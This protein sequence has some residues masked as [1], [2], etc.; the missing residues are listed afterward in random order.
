MKDIKP[1]LERKDDFM[2]RIIIPIREGKPM[3]N[4]ADEIGISR[5]RLYGVLKLFGFRNRKDVLEHDTYK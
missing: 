1:W 5:Q 4:I 2:S 3:Q